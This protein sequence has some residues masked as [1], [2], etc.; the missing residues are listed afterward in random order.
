VI[1]ADTA[2]NAHSRRWTHR[3]SAKSVVTANTDRVLIVSEALHEGA[4][5]DLLALDT[6]IKLGLAQMSGQIVTSMSIDTV[7]R[8]LE[9]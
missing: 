1:F 7:R 3:Q 2:G 6:E 4:Q 5:R 9:F 8:K